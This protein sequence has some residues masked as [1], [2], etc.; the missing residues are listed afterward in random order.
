M[1][2]ELPDGFGACRIAKSERR[3]LKTDNTIE[4]YNREIKRRLR[5]TG[6]LPNEASLLKVVTAIL[7]EITTVD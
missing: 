5:V 1:E 4:R 6:S 2:S 3:H 7:I